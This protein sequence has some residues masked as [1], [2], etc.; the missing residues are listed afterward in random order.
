MTFHRNDGGRASD[1]ISGSSGDCVVRAIAIATGR[2]Y[3]QV[4]DMVNEAIR[5]APLRG[6]RA[7]RREAGA[8]GA[9]KGVPKDIVRSLMAE[10]DWEWHPTM[11]IGSGCRVHLR[12]DELPG[13]TIICQVSR[14]LVA[15]IDGVIHDTRDPSR[16]GTRCVYGYWTDPV[17]GVRS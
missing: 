12:A 11:G 13:G 8:W 1:G 10:L 14:H 4:H 7:A 17:A 16:N 2:D 15:V 6:R 9:R 5:E 3:R